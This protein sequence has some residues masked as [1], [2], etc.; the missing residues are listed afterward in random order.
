M[1]VRRR[2]LPA[3]IFA[4]IVAAVAGRATVAAGDPVVTVICKASAPW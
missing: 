2:G 3:L 1:S 4:V